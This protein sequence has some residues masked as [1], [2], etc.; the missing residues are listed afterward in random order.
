M[1]GGIIFSFSQW[2]ITIIIIIIIIII[3]KKGQGGPYVY[4]YSMRV[5]YLA[6]TH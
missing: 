2:I 3:D 5:K 4:L 1:T 6:M